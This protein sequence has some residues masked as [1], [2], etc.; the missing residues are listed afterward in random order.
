MKLQPLEQRVRVA[1]LSPVSRPSARTHRP[2]SAELRISGRAL[3]AR[4]DRIRMR[5]LCTCR[6]CGHVTATHEGE[7]DHRIP[8]SRGGND[9]D[10]NLQWL[11]KPCHRAKT[12]QEQEL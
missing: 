2:G 12:K 8:L 1:D 10:E 6:A 3:Q 9:D 11:C 7:V 5:D 4:N